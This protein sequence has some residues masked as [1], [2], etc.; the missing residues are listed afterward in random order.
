M[1]SGATGCGIGN[2]CMSSLHGLTAPHKVHCE[3]G[4]LWPTEIEP[5]HGGGGTSTKDP[6]SKYYPRAA[7]ELDGCQLTADNWTQALAWDG[8]VWWAWGWVQ[9]VASG[10]THLLHVLTCMVPPQHSILSIPFP[11]ALPC[12]IP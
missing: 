11:Y 4:Y 3:A 8:Y 10:C 7:E 12:I 1:P 5:L 6:T 9:G 2:D